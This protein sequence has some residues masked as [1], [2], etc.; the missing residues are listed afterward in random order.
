M[1]RGKLFGDGSGDG[2]R[3]GPGVVQPSSG[4]MAVEPAAHME[5]LLEVVLAVVPGPSLGVLQFLVDGGEGAGECVVGPAVEVEGG[6]DT[7]TAKAE[8]KE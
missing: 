3:G 4:A 1:G 7:S 5:L 8:W 6:P 2:I